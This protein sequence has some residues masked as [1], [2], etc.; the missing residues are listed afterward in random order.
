[1]CGGPHHSAMSC[2]LVDEKEAAHPLLPG[3]L[4]TASA[5][6]MLDIS[7]ND[8]SKPVFASIVLPALEV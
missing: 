5:L 1:M 8:I 4:Q 3:V 6:S 7:G 2:M